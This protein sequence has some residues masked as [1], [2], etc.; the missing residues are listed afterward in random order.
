MDFITG[1][2][3]SGG[4]TYHVL[5]MIDAF[6]KYCILTLAK[7]RKSATVAHALTTKL[8]AYF[9]T[10]TVIQCDNGTEFKG[11]VNSLCAA[12]GVRLQ[13][14]LPYSSH[15]QG[16]VERLHRT[17]EQLLARTTTTLPSAHWP[18]LLPELQYTINVTYQRS[19]GC[20]PYL[21]MFGNT[22]PTQAPFLPAQPS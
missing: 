1:V 7:D 8:F 20:A 9:G 19:L 12:K 6:S 18:T 11:D 10:P 2:G 13:R 4:P 21:V 3:P 16:K 14:S 22:P 15:V 5:T 17:L